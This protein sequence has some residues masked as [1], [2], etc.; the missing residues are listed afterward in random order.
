MG[1]VWE[2]SGISKLKIP[3]VRLKMVS[4]SL[5]YGHFNKDNDENYFFF[6]EIP[7]VQT[8]PQ[9]QWTMRWCEVWGWLGD[10]EPSEARIHVLASIL[11]HTNPTCM[12]HACVYMDRDLY[13]NRFNTDSSLGIYQSHFPPAPQEM[14]GG[15]SE[16][17]RE[18][19]S[20]SSSL[21]GEFNTR[22]ISSI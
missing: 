12:S 20:C 6:F 16:D 1:Y 15:N 17:V 22:I 19:R 14:A 4:W 2:L 5:M 9:I 13:T 7:C 18:H 11:I 10:P 8:N 21:G 3:L